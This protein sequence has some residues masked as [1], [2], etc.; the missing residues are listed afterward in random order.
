MFPLPTLKCLFL[1]AE[2]LGGD[3]LARGLG[4]TSPWTQPRSAPSRA[5]RPRGPARRGPVASSS[6]GA[7]P[8][9]LAR[10]RHDGG[11][12]AERGFGRGKYRSP[13]WGWQT[14][15]GTTTPPPVLKITIRSARSSTP[16]DTSVSTAAIAAPPSGEKSIPSRAV[17]R[18]A[19]SARASSDTATAPP[20]LSRSAVSI[21]RSP[22]GRGHPE[23]AGNRLGVLPWL[24]P[25]AARG[26][27]AHHRRTPARLHREHPGA[28]FP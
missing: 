16:E 9:C 26:E 22:Q 7:A 13:V 27:G 23:P 3:V 8:C 2:H 18:R 20:P 12:R 25:V 15:S 28:T 17:P 19:A 11:G 24:G 4:K 6:S 5:S 10:R 14:L 1:S 21:R